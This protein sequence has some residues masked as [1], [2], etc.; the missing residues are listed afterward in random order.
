MTE[1][2]DF[3]VI[4]G[5]SSGY[6]GAT[7]ATRL[8]LKTAVIEGGEEV[9]GLCILRGCMP[10]KTMIESANRFATIRRAQEFG[11]RADNLAVHGDEIIARKK[12]LV[13]EFADYRRNQLE[14]GS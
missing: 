8:G 12:R 9:G 14:S 11:L 10:S 5:G 13:A 4:G 1:E 2:Y 7:T 3:V 6:A